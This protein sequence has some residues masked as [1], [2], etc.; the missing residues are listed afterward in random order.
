MFPTRAVGKNRSIRSFHCII[1]ATC[2]IEPTF[3]GNGAPSDQAAITA[4]NKQNKKT[5]F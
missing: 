5:T 1:E 3:A 2:V 4:E